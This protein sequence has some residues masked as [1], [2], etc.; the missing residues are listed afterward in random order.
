MA[1]LEEAQRRRPDLIL[2]D[3]M[4]PQLD[5][6]GLLRAVRND[7]RLREVPVILL[8]ARAGEDAQV[9]GLNAGA[10]DYLTKPFAARELV[11]RVGA[12]LEMARLRRESGAALRARTAELETLLET[13]PA[14]VWFTNDPDA[15]RVWGNRRAAALLRL[16]EGANPSFTG[17]EGERSRH[18]RVYRAGVEAERST[19]PLQRAL[20]G[21]EVR[22]DEI[23]IRFA[24]GGLLILLVHAAALRDST[25]RI[26]GAV[27]AGVD[28]TAHKNAEADLRRFNETLEERVVAEIEQRLQAETALRQ[29]QKMEAIGQLTGGVAHDMNNLLMVIQGNLELLERQLAPAP[30]SGRLRQ[31]VRRA[32]DGVERAA[33]LT[34]RLLAFARRQPLDPKPVE[35]DRL[36]AGMSDLLRRTLGETI[37]IETRLAGG[38]WRIFADPNQLENAILNLAVNARDAMPEG[39]TLTLET[40]NAH[41][42]ADGVGTPHEAGSGDYVLIA[43]TDTGIGMP[44]EHA[45]R[46]F[47][48]FFTTKDVGKGTGLG[49]SQVYGFVKQSGGNVE[50]ESEPGFGTTVRIYL[51]RYMLDPDR[52]MPVTAAPVPTATAGECI[53]VVEDSD[54]VRANNIGS[55]RELGYRVIAARDGAEALRR[56]AAEPSIVLLFTDVGLPGGM[57]GRQLADAARRLRP[58]LRVL[59]TTG[60][61]GDAIVRNGQIVGGIAVILK[62]FTHAALAAKVRET[63]DRTPPG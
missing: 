9:E 23:E 37:A 24:D 22:H 6:F 33:A 53:L 5:G 60:Y 4:M 11:A 35:P 13:V 41:L 29:A 46:A 32:L 51:P 52:P 38:L 14:G 34:Q 36:V 48:P 39:G 47:E 19:L 8:S 17:R 2:S 45:D 18:F 57:N 55:L 42:D 27:C 58:E 62:P 3:A 31:P 15:R 40:A 16:T 20:R 10:D 43:V 12:N 50:I 49:L 26:V 61:A 59:F 7:P 1:A 21:E 28:I 56:L 30:R 44:R 54:E 25:G 63:L